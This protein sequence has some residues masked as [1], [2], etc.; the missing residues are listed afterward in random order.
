MR[1]RTLKT[2]NLAA[3]D[4]TSQTKCHT[5]GG[6]GHATWQTM[7]GGEKLTCPTKVLGTGSKVTK[8]SDDGYSKLKSKYNKISREAKELKKMVLM[9]TS[10]VNKITTA[11]YKGETDDE[12]TT[13][14]TER[15]TTD[16]SDSDSGSESDGSTAS[17][18]P[19]MAD[20]VMKATRFSSP[21]KKKPYKKR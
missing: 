4:V 7:E 5:C 14:E 21:S 18:V 9:L 2:V 20:L 6:E 8:R 3:K 16:Q 13:N 12:T 15:E 17:Q 11:T 10:Q 1:K 19:D